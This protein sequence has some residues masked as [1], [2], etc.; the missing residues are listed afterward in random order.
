MA[1]HETF[2]KDSVALSLLVGFGEQ[3]PM[4][5]LLLLLTMLPEPEH[6]MHC[7]A[8]TDAASDC[9]CCCCSAADER[10]DDC[11]ANNWLNH[12][13]VYVSTAK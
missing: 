6:S 10:C 5:L 2:E 4:M 9:Y 3:A 13:N 7:D 11:S 1:D 12:R 8:L